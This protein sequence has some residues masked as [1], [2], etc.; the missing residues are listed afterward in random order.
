MKKVRLVAD[1]RREFF[2][3]VAYYEQERKGLGSRFRKAAESAFI[4]AGE[5][6]ASGKPGISGTRR[7]LVKGFPF[8]VVYLT[9]E[10]DVMVYAVAHLSRNPDYGTARLPSGG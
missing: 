10:S 7:L 5:Q 2:K 8:A 3:E 9:S 6:P 1:A 4:R